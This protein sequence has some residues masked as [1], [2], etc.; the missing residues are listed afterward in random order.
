MEYWNNGTMGKSKRI[1][2]TGKSKERTK[3][4]TAC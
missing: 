2:I 3:D 1:G 4:W